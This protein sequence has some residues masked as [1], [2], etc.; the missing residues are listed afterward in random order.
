[1]RGIAGLADEVLPPVGARHPG[2]GEPPIEPLGEGDAIGDHGDGG[3]GWVL[4]GQGEGGRRRG[5]PGRAPGSRLCCSRASYASMPARISASLGSLGIALTRIGR[6][7]GGPDA[8]R[9]AAVDEDGLFLP[10]ERDG[11]GQVPRGE[12]RRDR[13]GPGVAQGVRAPGLIGGA[14][15]RELQMR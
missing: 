2:H 3:L 4:G 7:D 11:E 5:D 10:Q 13:Q 12:R 1:M 14:R 8:D 15:G 6:P 9:R